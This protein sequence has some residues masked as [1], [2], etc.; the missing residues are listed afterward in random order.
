MGSGQ[1]RNGGPHARPRSCSDC[2]SRRRRSP[3]RRTSLRYSSDGHTRSRPARTPGRAN[4]FRLAGAAHPAASRSAPRRGPAAG[5]APS[6]GRRDLGALML[7]TRVLGNASRRRTAPPRALGNA[8][9]RRTAP[10][11]VL[12]NASQKLQHPARRLDRGRRELQQ[13]SRSARGA[14][15]RPTT[16]GPEG[17]FGAFPEA[18]GRKSPQPRLLR[19]HTRDLTTPAHLWKL[20]SRD[21]RTPSDILQI[22]AASPTTQAHLFRSQTPRLTT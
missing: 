5:R 10:A 8:S 15:L 6:N 17:F 3:R 11:R 2:H 20:R 16:A 19:L 18:S 1:G 13:A 4:C 12:G 22:P 14:G 7:V 21:L 9:R